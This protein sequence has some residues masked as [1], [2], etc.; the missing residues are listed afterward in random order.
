MTELE[1]LLTQ[2]LNAQSERVEAL[3]LRVAQLQRAVNEL[4][5]TVSEL[6]PLLERQN[7]G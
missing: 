3:I 7:S 5:Q 4:R 1:R 2:Q 6:L